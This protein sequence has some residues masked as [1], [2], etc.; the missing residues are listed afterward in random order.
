[1][2]AALDGRTKSPHLKERTHTG[3]PVSDIFSAIAATDTGIPLSTSKT[4]YPNF[5]GY[6]LLTFE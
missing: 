4:V 1:M 5:G 2:F 3:A 6:E